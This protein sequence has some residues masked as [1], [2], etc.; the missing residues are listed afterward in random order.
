MN[1]KENSI[2]WRVIVTLS[3]QQLHYIKYGKIDKSNIQ[4]III[5]P[6]APPDI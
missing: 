1:K 4:S 6:S 3:L 5:W 2:L